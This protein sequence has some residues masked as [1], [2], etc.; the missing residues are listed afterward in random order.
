MCSATQT[1]ISALLSNLPDFIEILQRILGRLSHLKPKMPTLSTT[2][3]GVDGIRV[4]PKD[5]I[6]GF[7]QGELRRLRNWSKWLLGKKIIHHLSLRG[8]TLFRGGH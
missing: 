7:I 5:N 2:S 6:G 1:R 8:N 3:P 4:G